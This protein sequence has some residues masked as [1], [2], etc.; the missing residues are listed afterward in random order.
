MGVCFIQRSIRSIPLGIHFEQGSVRS[1]P[2]GVHGV[3]VHLCDRAAQRALLR[4][5]PRRLRQFHTH[6]PRLRFARLECMLAALQRGCQLGAT[7]LEP[8][9]LG[10]VE[11][12]RRPQLV[13]ANAQPLRRR[14]RRH[15]HLR[16]LRRPHR[17]L[18]ASSGQPALQDSFH[19][20]QTAHLGGELVDPPRLP[21][22]LGLPVSKRLARLLRLLVARLRREL[23]RR[24]RGLGLLCLGLEP[25]V[26]RRE[27]FDLDE[28]L[29]VGRQIVQPL[30]LRA[31]VHLLRH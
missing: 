28:V 5:L 22:A 30:I 15:L 7:A 8:T 31:G 14:R 11:L 3:L 17:L 19:R 26:L 25:L 23:M 13:P 21:R 16:R 29:V 6:P 4:Q 24:R 9:Q 12:R 10:G 2:L 27:F 1:F 20:S 18:N